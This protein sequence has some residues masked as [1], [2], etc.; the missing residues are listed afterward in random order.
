MLTSGGV[1]NPHV[2]VRVAGPCDVK[3]EWG[4]PEQ[5]VAF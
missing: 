2:V 1:Q 4:H 3:A 5:R